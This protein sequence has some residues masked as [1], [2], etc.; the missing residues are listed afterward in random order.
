[1]TLEASGRAKTSGEFINL[2]DDIRRQFKAVTRR[3]INQQQEILGDCGSFQSGR[4][5]FDSKLA[6]CVRD[7][8]VAFESSTACNSVLISSLSVLKTRRFSFPE[9]ARKCGWS[10]KSH[11]GQNVGPT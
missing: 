11:K 1:M 2:C 6:A 3:C 7:V 10:E 5:G 9:I 8:R 4:P